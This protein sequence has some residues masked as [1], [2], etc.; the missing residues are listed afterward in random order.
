[1]KTL[2]IEELKSQLLEILTEVKA[3]EEVLIISGK[4]RENIAMLI[5]Y[6]KY[7]KRK[8]IK[9]GL[10]KDKTMKIHNDFKMTTEE[11]ISL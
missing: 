5:P 11:L 10:L 3:G 7:K 6:T 9:L 1:M 2:Q 4:F 8:S